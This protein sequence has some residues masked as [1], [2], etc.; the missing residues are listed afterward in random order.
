M[1]S[2]RDV[3]VV[4]MGRVG[5]RLVHELHPERSLTVIDTSAE[6]LELV[7][8]QVGRLQVNRVH[9]DATSRLVLQQA[10]L[11]PQTTLVVATGDDEVNREVAR[12][13]RSEFQVEEIVVLTRGGFDHRED[14][15]TESDVLERHSATAALVL[16]RLNVGET[17]GVALGLGKG[18]L[19]QVSVMEGSAAA[20][21]PLSEIHPH[22][23]LVAAVY[24]DDNLLVPHGQTVLRPGDRVLLVGQPDVLGSV[25][26]FIRGGRP[27][28]PTQY[29]EHIGVLGGE[30]ATEEATWLLEHTLASQTVPL[31]AGEVHPDKRSEEQIADYLLEHKVGCVVLDPVRISWAARIGLISSSRK[32]FVLAAHMPILVARGSKPYKRILMAVGGNQDPV[33]IGQVGIDLARQNAAELTVLTVLPPSF[34]EGEEEQQ[35]LR[36]MPERVAHIARLHGVN[37]EQ[38]IDHGNPIERIRH[39]AQEFDLLVVGHSHSTRNTVFTPDV[40]L[41]LLHDTPCSVMFVPWNA[42]GQ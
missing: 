34:A 13:A 7:P 11:E 20:G 31:E 19:R 8:T 42:A 39:H 3:V 41:F 14:G 35:P 40:S 29:G 5:R 10:G 26:A 1:L 25:A 28:F 24:R 30:A 23:W 9:G 33:L 16:N 21:R 4:G 15:I 12:V 36:A 22:R 17:R 6:R 32:R 37:V 2:T 27:I 38:R 18:E